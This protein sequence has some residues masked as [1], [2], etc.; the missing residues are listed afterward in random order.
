MVKTNHNIDNE[1]ISLSGLKR[2]VMNC[3]QWHN[4]IKKESIAAHPW[5]V[6]EKRMSN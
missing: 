2:C 1:R 3:V 5:L 6:L 4:S